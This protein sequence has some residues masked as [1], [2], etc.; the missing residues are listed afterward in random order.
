MSDTTV[1]T[2]TPSP[3]PAPPLPNTS[4][5]R[6]PQGELK[7]QAPPTPTPTSTT[8]PKEET[9]PPPAPAAPETYEA[10]KLPE[11]V[12]LEGEQLES[13]TKLFKDMGLSQEKAQ[14]LVDFHVAQLKSVADA[15]SA[16]YEAMR[17]D[18]QAKAKA[19]PDIGPKMDQIK[20]NVGRLYA[21]IGDPKLVNDFKEVM[22]LTG[23]GDNPAFIKML[24]KLS[25][26]VTEGR[27]VAASGPS[28]HGQRAPGTSERPTAAAALYPNNP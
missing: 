10:F 8:T 1:T 13:A 2:E 27:H 11:G 3:T 18:W 28:A 24:N 7:D 23:A 21:S 15:S 25:A 14:S 12:K 9:K 5:A 22:N 19:D 16:A 6:T 17:A 26:F 4:E 20:E